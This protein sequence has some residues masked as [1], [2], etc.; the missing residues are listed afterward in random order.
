MSTTPPESPLTPGVPMHD[1]L[2]A[3]VIQ[4]VQAANLSAEHLTTA[5]KELKESYKFSRR[6]KAIIAIGTGVLALLLALLV[7]QVIISA[8]NHELASRIKSC[9]DPAGECYKQGSARTNKA[10]QAIVASDV[11]AFEA[12]QVCASS[13]SV[14][15]SHTANNDEAYYRALTAC[16][17]KRLSHP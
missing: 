11:R 10:V 12:V 14:I 4:Q 9:T 8:R 15:N 1:A 16:V 13:V 2:L 3:A 5:A 6:L 17:D 7:T